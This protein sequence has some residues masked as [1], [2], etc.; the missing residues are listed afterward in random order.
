MM[1]HMKLFPV[2]QKI[3]YQQ[4]SDLL[5]TALEGGSNYWYQIIDSTEPNWG[6][7]D[8]YKADEHVHITDYPLNPMGNIKLRSIVDGI[9][10][11]EVN[12]KTEWDVNLGTI[13]R[14]LQI[15][16]TKYP[17]HFA[18]AVSEQNMDAW[19]ADVFL[20]CVCFGEIVYG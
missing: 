7:L 6:L 18:D 16:A 12:G 3:T 15:M 13:K 9:E 17:K 8:S 14:G 5:I 19:T 20:Q 2:T 11:D 4:V 10:G 1:D